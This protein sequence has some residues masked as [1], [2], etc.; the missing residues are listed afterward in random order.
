MS[1]IGCT[2]HLLDRTFDPLLLINSLSCTILQFK[3]CYNFIKAFNH[4]R[5]FQVHMYLAFLQLLFAG[6]FEDQAIE[7]LLQG[8]ISLKSMGVVFIQKFFNSVCS[9][10]NLPRWP[11]WRIRP[12]HRTGHYGCLRN[13]STRR[14]SQWHMV[15]AGHVHTTVIFYTEKCIDLTDT[16][17]SAKVR[18]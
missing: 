7:L 14:G 6:Q 9:I 4:P 2:L 12:I 17:V 8:K 15:F 11:F 10:Q 5:V 1:D 3:L 16:I 13:R 18:Q